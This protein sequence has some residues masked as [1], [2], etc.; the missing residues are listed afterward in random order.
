MVLYGDC[1]GLYREFT[2]LCNDCTGLYR[3]L[4]L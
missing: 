1:I 3:D 4:I 2:G